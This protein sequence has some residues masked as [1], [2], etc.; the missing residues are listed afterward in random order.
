MKNIELTWVT[1]NKNFHGGPLTGFILKKDKCYCLYPDTAKK[2][3]GRGWVSE[4]KIQR[5]RKKPVPC[6]YCGAPGKIHS[7]VC[8][9]NG[10][11]YRKTRP[12]A[13]PSW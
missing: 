11:L 5:R 2:F 10:E 6:I 7:D 12:G 1:A 4:G 3:I 8:P 9:T 13:F